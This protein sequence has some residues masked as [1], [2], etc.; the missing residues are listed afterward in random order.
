MNHYFELQNLFEATEFLD[1]QSL[2]NEQQT[3][4]PRASSSLDCHGPQFTFDQIDEEPIHVNRPL[5]G[6]NVEW[7]FDPQPPAEEQQKVSRK[8]S[9]SSLEDGGWLTDFRVL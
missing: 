4:C 2:L 9:V 8:C 3:L 7:V 6:R 1:C 5:L